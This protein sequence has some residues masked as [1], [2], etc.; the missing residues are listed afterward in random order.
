[1]KKKMTSPNL[2]WR[3][4]GLLLAFLILLAFASFFTFP[5]WHHQLPFN[6]DLQ[7]ISFNHPAESSNPIQEAY[8]IWLMPPKNLRDHFKKEMDS[9]ARQYS[10][11]FH[12]PHATLVTTASRD[13]LPYYLFFTF[14]YLIYLIRLFLSAEFPQ[15]IL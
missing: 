5:S 15:F 12:E 8:S 4:Q 7:S 14:P 10:G 1:M 9:L 6:A 2:H 11:T 3:L 13:H